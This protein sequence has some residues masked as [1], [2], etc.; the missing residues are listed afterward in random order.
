MVKSHFLMVKGAKIWPLT[1]QAELAKQSLARQRQRFVPP[2]PPPDDDMRL[3][4]EPQAP[5]GKMNDENRGGECLTDELCINVN[6]GVINPRLFIKRGYH[7]TSQL[8]LFGGTTIINQPGFIN[9]GLTLF[10]SWG[11]RHI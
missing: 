8:L 10:N 1:V 6:P 9:P 2:P 7:S 4:D 11:H 5:S 3:L